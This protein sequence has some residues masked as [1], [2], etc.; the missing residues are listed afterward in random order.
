MECARDERVVSGRTRAKRRGRGA[1]EDVV[2]RDAAG[3]SGENAF[4][5][6]PD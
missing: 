3:V 2:R 1:R 5:E 6:N 4:P